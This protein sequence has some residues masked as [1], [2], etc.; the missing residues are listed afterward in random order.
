MF[1]RHLNTRLVY[2]KL[3]LISMR[4]QCNISCLSVNF[5]LNMQASTPLIMNF[6]FNTSFFKT[7]LYF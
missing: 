4:N 6:V 1:T 5:M 3:S 7:V 2:L